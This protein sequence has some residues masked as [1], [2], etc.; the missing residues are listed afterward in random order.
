[1]SKQE[2]KPYNV[3]KSRTIITSGGGNNMIID[4]R[5]IENGFKLRSLTILEIER[6]FTFPVNYTNVELCK[7]KRENLLGNSIVV[8]VIEY[9]LQY[10]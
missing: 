2:Y 3:G 5:F 9:I 6:L 1:M 4:R 10:L 7:S 8:K